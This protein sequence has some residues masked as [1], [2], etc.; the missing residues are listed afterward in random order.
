MDLH[1]Q[2]VRE[3]LQRLIN[4][5]SYAKPEKCEF[6]RTV[7]SF[8]GYVISAEGVAMDKKVLTHLIWSPAASGTFQNLKERFTLASILHHPDPELEF[9]VEVDASNT[10]IRAVLLPCHGNPPKI[11]PC[12]FYLRLLN[13]GM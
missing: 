11:F 3:V 4:N 7:T 13:R 12:A 8:L 6:H 2:H 10:D 1:V 5:Q 9:T